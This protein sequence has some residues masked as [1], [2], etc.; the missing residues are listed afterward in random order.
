MFDLCQQ[1]LGGESWIDV[2]LANEESVVD[3][4]GGV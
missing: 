1:L 3:V 4:C 2:E